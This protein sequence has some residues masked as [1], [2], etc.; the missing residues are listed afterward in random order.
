MLLSLHRPL[1]QKVK[2]AEK[3]SYLLKAKKGE[4][5][6]VNLE[7]QGID[8]KIA[9]LD[10]NQQLITIFDTTKTVDGAE[11]IHFEAQQTG[12]YLLQVSPSTDTLAQEGSYLI[13]FDTRLSARGYQSSLRQQQAEQQKIIE[14]IRNTAHPIRSL[15]VNEDFNDLQALSN[16]LADVQVV[17]LGEATHGSREFFQL[18]H[19]FAAFLVKQM[20]FTLFAL[21][22]SYS[23]CLYINEYVLT[24]KGSLDTAVAMQGFNTYRTEEIKA[25]IEWLRNYNQTVP[26]E[27]KVQFAGFDLQV[28][29]R[30]AK[31][32]SEYCHKVDKEKS[33][34]IDT[35]LAVLIQLESNGSW[36]KE[37]F[38]PYIA[39]VQELMSW[40]VLNKGK[41]SLLTSAQEYEQTWQHLRLLLQ[42]C[43]A[44]GEASSPLQK[45]DRDYFMAENINYIHSQQPAGT[46][47]IVW[48]HNGHIGKDVLY[49]DVYSM[50]HYL[51]ESYGEDYY[52]IG[53]DFYQGAFQANDPHLKNSPGWEEHQI[54]PAGEGYFGWFG[55][56]SGLEQFY[57]D[58]HK[59][60]P[61]AVVDKW[62][63]EKK[64]NFYS[65]GSSFS[66]KWPKEE[67][68]DATIISKTYDGIIYIENS[69]R[70]KPIAP[71][72]IKFEIK[73]MNS[74][75]E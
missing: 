58:I 61:D 42:Y 48:A 47:M 6:A 69:T 34:Q 18:K 7:Q 16:A 52:A 41:F 32:V 50:G 26:Q 49:E 1:S 38:S 68:T 40:F 62:L 15:Q 51:Q 4:Y 36:G 30:A 60:T 63:Q 20:G 64:I 17:G 59:K 8:L 9:L 73:Q 67:Y 12:T 39:K 37:I 33:Q 24:G 57:L 21:E 5:I 75:D 25:L 14:W 74:L 55:K 66:K 72:Q 23:R 70:A 2:T 65:I 56:Q 46:K 43:L 22:A 3:Y 71:L 35:L 53:F 44:M 31:L 13:S 29:D 27:K 19:R 45:Q 28:N 10:A 11:P 54:G